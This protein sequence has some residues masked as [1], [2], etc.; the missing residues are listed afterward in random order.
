LGEEGDVIRVSLIGTVLVLAGLVLGSAT[1]VNAANPLVPNLKALPASELRIEV[2]GDGSRHLRFSTTS[3]NIGDGPL[4]V[5][6]GLVTGDSQQVDQRVYDSA[7]GFV[8]YSAGFMTYH[9]EHAHMHFDDYAEMVLQPVDAS[10]ASARTGAKQTFCIIDTDKYNTRLP[11]SPKRAV[12]TNCSSDVQG[13]SVGWGDTYR[14][15]LFGQSIDISGLPDGIYDLQIRIDPKD[16]LV[17]KDSSDN[18]STVRIELAGNSVS[19]IGGATG[20]GRGN[21]RR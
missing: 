5:R 7:G 14:Y 17:E 8:D 1:T 9:V 15:Y 10:G 3:V 16:K 4:E 21:G 6:G 18:V 12:Y 20:P 11:G 2:L 13:M 19:Q